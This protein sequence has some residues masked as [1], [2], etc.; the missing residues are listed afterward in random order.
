MILAIVTNNRDT[1]VG[2][3]PPINTVLKP[4]E[5]RRIPIDDETTL[6][7]SPGLNRALNEGW[8]SLVIEEPDAQGGFPS[9][10]I[11][12]VTRADLRYVDVFPTM[13]VDGT[14]VHTQA[15]PYIGGTIIATGFSGVQPGSPRTLRVVTTGTATGQVNFDGILA[16]GDG[17]GESV[18]TTTVGTYE[19]LAAWATVSS[20]TLPALG[21]ISDTIS[22]QVSSKLG[23]IGLISSTESLY[24]VTKNGLDISFAPYRVN[25]DF[26]T[27]DTQG[28]AANDQ[29]ILRYRP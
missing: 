2:I 19:G 15:G 11:D 14:V 16:T 7:S 12:V 23:L 28:I 29:Y 17:F 5:T 3:D 4:H 9:L 10:P 24:K 21:S 13:A 25:P 1:S 22:V 26:S 18:L 6:S 27:F 20:I 8:I